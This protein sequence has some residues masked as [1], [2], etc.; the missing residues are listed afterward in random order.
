MLKYQ[1]TDGIIVEAGLGAIAGVKYAPIN[2]WKDF[3]KVNK[4]LCDPSNREKLKEI[5]QTI[6]FDEVYASARMCQA[7]ICEKYGADNISEQLP[8]GSTVNRPN[9][10]VAYESEYWGEIQKLLKAGFSIVFIGHEE[11][12]KDTGQI[13]P[14]GDKRSMKVI[15]DNADVCLYL[16]SNGINPETGR[17][18]FSSAYSAETPQ[19][20]A[21]SRYMHMKPFIPEFTAKNVEEALTE[22]IR[23]ESEETGIAPVSYEERE[24]Q[25]TTTKADFEETKQKCMELC[26]TLDSNGFGDYALELMFKHL[27]QGVTLST[28]MERQIDSLELLMIDLQDFSNEK[29]LTQ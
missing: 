27:G 24:A 6:I 2:N 25:M 18:V 17:P 26:M 13:I 3:K 16:V 1:E 11:T 21:R 12:D 9:L 29:E 4:K 5:Y 28:V 19:F 8:K 23:L 22:A 15:R 14:K 10:Y 20:F 7:F